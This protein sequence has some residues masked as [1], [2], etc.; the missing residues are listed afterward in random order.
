MMN[1]LGSATACPLE[2]TGVSKIYR[3]YIKI[4]TANP[5]DNSKHF[6]RASSVLH[7]LHAL[8][9]RALITIVCIKVKR[10][11]PHFIY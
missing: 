11:Y 1:S 7:G 9:Y 6:M 4:T 2:N 5:H 3:D 8:T 10:L